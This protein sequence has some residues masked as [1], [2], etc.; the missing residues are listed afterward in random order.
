MT[1]DR[2]D[3]AIVGG[4]MITN[5]LLLP[6]IYHMQRE[7]WIG[8]IQVCA[9]NSAP[10]RALAENPE[11]REAFPDQTFEP[12]PSLEEAPQKDF[13]D[14]YREVLSRLAPY[15]AVVVAMPDSLHY[16]VILEA[17]KNCQHV[18]C[19]KPLVLR[20]EQALEIEKRA[21]EKGLFV[22]VEYH[23]RFDRRAL[24]ARREYRRGRWGE[25]VIGEAKMIEPYSYRFSN[26]QNWF[27]VDV[28]DPFVY[29]GCHYVD[30]VWFITG[31][32]P[33]TVSVTGVK[34]RFPNGN[35]GYLWANGRVIFENGAILNVTD[36][37]GYPDDAAGSNE[38]GLVLY[39]EGSGQCGY[40]RH[41][42][43]F[44]GV[45]HSYLDGKKFNYINPD[46]YRLAP[47]EGKGYKPVGYGYDSV[48]AILGTIRRIGRN[49][50]G[51]Q[52]GEALRKRQEMIHQVDEMGI[53]ATPA[54]SS[55]NELVVE[56]ARESIRNG[57]D[58]VHIRYGESP[59]IERKYAR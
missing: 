24:I 32:H 47:W 4:G 21:S 29:V 18:L 51:M 44:R 10:L 57:G 45:E 56:A 2:L 36:G 53:I 27:T 25:F 54:N 11:I 7:G 6:S 16:E 12:F 40:L 17:L 8:R 52:E 41:N 50:D 49:T 26:F 37:L 42:D 20:H 33:V 28:T 48:A 14:L 5:D 22:G 43:Q 15:Q 58:L 3:V 34:G 38:Q 13:P 23:K 39:F 1:H 59:R 31:L 9:L 19:V 55:I 35:E 30:Q 46:F